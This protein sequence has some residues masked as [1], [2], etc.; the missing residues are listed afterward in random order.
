MSA[1]SE[2]AQSRPEYVL[3]DSNKGWL[4]NVWVQPSAKSNAF[5]GVHDGS[6]K[7]RLAVPAME[8]KANKALIDFVAQRLNL[9]RRQI[10]IIQGMTGRRKILQIVA[11]EEPAWDRLVPG[12]PIVGHNKPRSGDHGT[13]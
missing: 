7:V 2:T 13:A 9:H 10:L 6:L 4:L 8:N 12:G 11:E 5:G 3:P 1:I